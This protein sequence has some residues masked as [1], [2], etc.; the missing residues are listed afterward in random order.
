MNWFFGLAQQVQ[1]Y[2]IVALVVALGI[3]TASA[4]V[5][6]KVEDAK[7]EHERT[8]H[9]ATRDKVARV[10]MESKSFQS[11]AKACSDAVMTWKVES[12]ALIK[13]AILAA[14]KAGVA[15]QSRYD[16]AREEKNRKPEN[17]NDLCWSAQRDNARYLRGLR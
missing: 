13:D 5:I 4:V 17:P 16:R 11:A 8:A 12:E 10:E 3:A 7:L 6:Y 14:V 2:I 1:M 9:Q 15:A